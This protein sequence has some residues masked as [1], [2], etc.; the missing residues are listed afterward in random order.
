[1]DECRP[2]QLLLAVLVLLSV[3]FGS[4][5]VFAH[6]QKQSPDLV[7]CP[8]QK[9][10][11]KRNPSAAVAPIKTF[12]LLDDVCA[13]NRLKENFFSD[14]SKSLHSRR[15]LSHQNDEVKLF[16]SYLERGE[17]VFAEIVTPSDAPNRQLAQSSKIEKSGGANYQKDFTNALTGKLFVQQFPR[18][19]TIKN[20]SFYHS[21]IVKESNII[22]HRTAP[23]APPIHS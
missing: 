19:P 3:L 5:P 14:L 12:K 9:S 13:S 15:I 1:M 21:R 18:P 4:L 22:S 7:Y 2:P 8:L 17:Q 23:R 20:S 11:V 10:W 16:F 6:T